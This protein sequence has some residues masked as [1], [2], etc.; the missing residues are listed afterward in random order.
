MNQL[1]VQAPRVLDSAQLIRIQG[2][3]RGLLYQHLYAV[4]CI[5][6]APRQRVLRIRVERDEDLELVSEEGV[7]YVQLKTRSGLLAPSDIEGMLER[8]DALRRSHTSEDREGQAQFALIANNELGPA[9][10]KQRWASDILVLTPSSPIAA[11]LDTGLMVPPRTLEE[12]YCRACELAEDYRQSALRPASLVAKLVGMVARAA[13]GDGPTQSFETKELPQLCELVAVELRPLPLADHYIPQRDEPVPDDCHGLVVIGHGGDGKSAWAAQWAAHSS[14]LPVYVPCTSSP[15]DSLAFRL[16]E[17]LHAALVLRMAVPAHELVTP[18]RVGLDSLSMLDR[19]VADR[20]FSVTAILDD[21]HH[22][23][24]AELLETVKA[25]P[26]LRWVLLGRPCQALDEVAVVMS[27]KREKLEGWDDDVLAALLRD[28]GCSTHPVEVAE[29]RRATDG[30]PLFALQAVDAVRRSGGATGA[31]AKALFEGTTPHRSAQ[32]I[33]LKGTLASLRDDAGR[34]ASA[35]AS[36]DVS[37]P[38]DEWAK[39]AGVALQLASVAFRRELRVLADLQVVVLTLGG[40]VAVHD[41]FRPL[42]ESRFLPDAAV[43]AVR[44]SVLQILKPHRFDDH[45][46]RRIRAYVSLLFS[47]GHL[48][49]LADEMS[50]CAEQ[51]RESGAIAHV[52]ATLETALTL[53]AL[54]AKDRF[55]MVDTLAYFDIEEGNS[56][57]A[58]TRLRMMES[59]EHGLGQRAKDAVTHKRMLVAYQQRD[60]ATSRAI[61]AKG[62]SDPRY[63]RVLQYHAALVESEAGDARRAVAD[64]LLLAKDYLGELGLDCRQVFGKNATEV[65]QAIRLD[66]EPDDVRHVADCYAAAIGI[67]R[68]LPAI[69]SPWMTVFASWALKF[70]GIAGADRSAIRAGQDFADLYLEVLDDPEGARKFCETYLLPALSQAQLPDLRVPVRAQYAVV[71]AW[72]GDFETADAEMRSLEPYVFAISRPE[73]AEYQNRCRLIDRIRARG[74]LSAEERALR[75][76]RLRRRGSDGKST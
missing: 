21:G 67:A 76:R 47:L 22:R 51:I 12:L 23:S 59:L 56:E 64:L 70:Y 43:T 25:A 33:V 28:S 75:E 58:S 30:A 71:C 60:L 37:L 3:H 7:R 31:Y 19:E 24:A 10:A 44:Q 54:S 20:H 41:L 40:D 72:C 49:D 42:L 73:Q 27:W 5:L 61:V 18:T 2:T 1:A 52:R 16:V 35:L 26:H 48:S 74:P 32:E 68:K 53:D 55:W 11:A 57:A 14:D 34:I 69:E 63:Q 4:L 13:A 29:L 45:N 9:L 17:A 46:G 65:V 15:G 36:V 8:F 66:A 50:A 6:A 38:V 39:V 62:H